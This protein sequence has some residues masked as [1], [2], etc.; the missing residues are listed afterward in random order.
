MVYRHPYIL[1]Y[2]AT[3]DQSGQKHL[4]TER[5]RPLNDVLT[6]LTD[7]EICLGLRTILCGLIFLIEKALARHLNIN[8]HSIYVTDRG[9]WRLAGFE[10]VWRATEVDKQL[11]DLAHSFINASISEENCEQFAFGMLCE[12]VLERSGTN[13]DDSN[14]TPHA[15]E[16]REYCGAHLKHQNTKL[17]PPFSVVLLHPYF[18]HEFVLIHSF[19][20]ELPLKSGQERHAFF[21]S[22]IERLQYFDEE[23][24][25]SQLACDL[26]SRMV[27]LDP[28][29]QEFVTPHILRTKSSV[30][31]T[32]SL[33][34]PHTYVQYL[35]PHI[36]KM[37]RLRDAQIRLILLD[38]FMDF[39]CL[40]GIEQ[41]QS[42]V[43]PQLQLGMSDTNDILVA[44]TLRCMADLVSILGASKVL[45]GE[46]SRCFS[47]G[48]P[49]AAVSTRS[50]NT[51]PEPRSISPLMDT[52]SF[53]VGDDFMVSSSP[54]PTTNN[55]LLLLRPSPDGGEDRKIGLNLNEKSLGVCQNSDPET[56]SNISVAGNEKTLVNLD[57]EGTWSHSDTIDV[58]QRATQTGRKE[59]TPTDL[60]T[61]SSASTRNTQ[62]LLSSHSIAILDVSLGASKA[63]L[64]TDR[65]IID[66]LNA[67]DIQ[68]QSVTQ[69]TELGEF[70]FFKDM[71]PV[72]EIKTRSCET[73]ERINSRFAAAALTANCN[74]VDA[75]NGWGH[76]EQDGDV[77]SW[78]AA[79][80]TVTF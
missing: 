65:K 39:V 43:L 23:I 11:I 69:G 46:R 29:A 20:F 3:W 25:A 26:L 41:L 64:Q 27:L 61:E 62:A 21:G 44:K 33:F 14:S 5:V 2:V 57:E 13:S 9:S 73:N 70:D 60:V 37:F 36:L 35:M 16:F 1:K 45:G 76:D 34:S 12:K 22:L 7:L 19:L 47:D 24:V 42:E 32:V 4:A 17:R 18:N 56:D 52:R 72:I 54:L 53:D 68:V 75:E 38:Y 10:Y 78:G 67:L 15:H 63:L 28:A 48:R 31:T 49:H 79:N 6:H 77:I 71:E 40:L 51:M 50:Q 80:E 8:I 55:V 66:D 58:L 59:Q 74:D 30:N